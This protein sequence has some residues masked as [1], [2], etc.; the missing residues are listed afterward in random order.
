MRPMCAHCIFR[1]LLVA[2]LRGSGLPMACFNRLLI[3][4]DIEDSIGACHT[5]TVGCARPVVP[6]KE[7]LAVVI[8]RAEA[9]VCRELTKQLSV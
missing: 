1:W 5:A 8:K 4:G 2:C 9:K 6:R 7:W 3:T